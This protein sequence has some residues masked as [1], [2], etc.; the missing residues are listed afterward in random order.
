M[1]VYDAGYAVFDDMKFFYSLVCL[2]GVRE[3]DYFCVCKVFL[4][5]TSEE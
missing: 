2:V 5:F 4:A 3:I 1:Y